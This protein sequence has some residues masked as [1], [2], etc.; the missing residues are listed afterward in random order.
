MRNT[1]TRDGFLHWSWPLP[2]AW[3]LALSARSHHLAL[4]RSALGVEVLRLG[5]QVHTLG[6]VLGEPLWLL[7]RAAHTAA[8]PH[9]LVACGFHGE[10]PAGPWGLLRFLQSVQTSDLDAVNLAL[11]PLVNCT[12]FAAGT[13]FNAQGDNPN[14][15]FTGSAAAAS[16][17][18]RLLLQHA[19]ALASASR[20]GVLS[21]H[22][23][24]LSEHAYLYALE[25]APQPG[26]QVQRLLQANLRHF[27][28]HPDGLVD[29]CAVKDGVIFN[30]HD[31]SFEDWLF[32]LGAAFAVC[33]ETPALQP[34]E[35]RVAAQ[36]DMIGNFVLDPRS[37]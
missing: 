10:E 28:P 16:A 29:G 26:P 22:E 35:S 1:A 5:L 25:Q 23:D 7:S 33:V 15:G 11:L 17:E 9:R 13:R 20:D 19:A 32:G 30:H 18:G 27:T 8:A 21:C 2:P 12:G 24:V 14:R 4:W 34:F 6:T 37:P 36:A 3:G 31:G